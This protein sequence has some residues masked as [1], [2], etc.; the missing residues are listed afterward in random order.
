M[1]KGLDFVF[2]ADSE[3]SDPCLQS[4]FRQEHKAQCAKQIT[5]YGSMWPAY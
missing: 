3:Y 5:A 1:N 2:Y 4:V